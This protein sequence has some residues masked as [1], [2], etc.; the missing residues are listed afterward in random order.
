MPLS[1]SGP[2]HFYTAD[3]EAWWSAVD[4]AL[5]GAPRDRLT[6]LTDDGLPVQPLYANRT[7]Q[8]ARA[9]RAKPGAWTISQRIDLPDVS[10]AN[11]QILQDLEGGASG[12][13]LVLDPIG[14]GTGRGIQIKTARD[15]A[16]LYAGVLPDLI[17]TR[18]DAGNK[19]LGLISEFL[20]YLKSAG[21]KPSTV[22]LTASYDPNSAAETDG[23]DLSALKVAA[24]ESVA[25]GS[26]LRLLTADG[27]T[28]HNAGAS[29]AQELALVLSSAVAHMRAL[30]NAG[31]EPEEWATRISIT[32]V[33]DADQ[34]GTISK[35]RAIRKLWASVLAGAG[36]KQDPADLH[37]VTSRRM[38]TQRDPWV[39][40]LR[41][42]VASFAAGVGG[43]DSVCVLPHTEAIGLPDAFARRLARN[44]QSM[45]LEESSL[46]KVMDPS[47][48]SGAIEA[49]TDQLCAA[50]WA[51]FQ[52][53]EAAGGLLAARKSGLVE[54][55]IAETRAKIEKDI[56]RRK[57]PITGV[58]EFPNLG[59]KPVE[60]L[61]K[62]NSGAGWRYAE[63]FEVLRAAADAHEQA[64]GQA[65]SIFLATLGPLAQFTARA[66]WLA[67]AFA[68]GG[69]K[70]SEAAVYGS[71]EEMAA[72][73][74]ESG[75]ALA[76]IV[77]SDAV[78]ENEAE[79]AAKALS[80]GGAKHIYL[81]GKPGDKEAAYRSAGVGTFVFAGCD[82]LELLRDAH[83]LLGLPSASA[84]QELEGQA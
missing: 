34:F 16:R 41:N 69:L 57:R 45:L 1:F 75:A 61:A 46:A 14:L 19:T 10:V 60:V 39:N 29:D 62:T 74:K 70:A 37:M 43:A 13:D 51:F 77:S 56:A 4:K 66:T 78:Y 27:Q 52:E 33:A 35:A 9:L 23:A 82:I 26:P 58:S 17:E 83:S 2:D 42:T 49:R 44:T 55:N 68:A 28:W 32:L 20:G 36:V 71:V 18:I 3:E 47:A 63:P 73:F 48:G 15:F 24:E 30:E 67:S 21:I 59:E 64:A 8:P 81:A 25:C 22:R 31:L 65:P 11:A 50:A 5:K 76:C 53:I 80:D 12:L 54:K 84:E 38:L 79:A 7:D 6:S 72:A 40:L